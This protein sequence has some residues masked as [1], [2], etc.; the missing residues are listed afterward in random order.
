V[1]RRDQIRI[2]RD[3][4]NPALTEALYQRVGL[5]APL[6]PDET[7]GIFEGGELIGCASLAGDV[8]VGFA[9]SPSVRG[10]G[11][12]TT[13][14][15]EL[16]KRGVER[17]LET[18]YVFTKPDR[19]FLFEACGFRV[20]AAAPP[21]VVMLEWGRP[22]FK[23][24]LASLKGLS[25]ARSDK[26]ALIVMNANPFTNGHKYLAT[27]ASNESPHLYVLVVEEDKSF[28]PFEERYQLVRE[29][30][31][32]LDNVTVIPSG[33]YVIS[34]LT[35][36]TYFL[37][38]KDVTLARADLDTHIFGRYIA[39]ALKVKVRYV[40]TEPYCQVTHQYNQAMKT[41][42]PDYGLEVREIARRELEAEAISAS[43]VRNLL[44]SGQLEDIK[45]LV[46]LSTYQYL[47]ALKAL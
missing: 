15:S 27:V 42:L 44:E 32:H 43:Q 33:Q 8:L 3:I 47:A 10:S 11:L 34:V 29:G 39:P 21:L 16:I 4:F 1:D 13:L 25:E 5:R 26:A 12:L 9:V 22:A 45:K 28:F 19:A 20:I 6:E 24:H 31:S 30:L 14:C 7:V 41:I 23:E 37:K 2:V 18:L 17:R 38:E 36:P 35:F 46:P 40:G